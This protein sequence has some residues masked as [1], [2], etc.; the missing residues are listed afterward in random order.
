MISLL[1]YVTIRLISWVAGSK[2]SEYRIFSDA[3]SKASYKA[4]FISVIRNPMTSFF[5]TVPFM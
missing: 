3:R 4:I 5:F 2:I 1:G